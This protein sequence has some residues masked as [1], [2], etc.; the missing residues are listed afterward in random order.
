MRGIMENHQPAAGQPGLYLE[1]INREL[2]QILGQASVPLYLSAFYGV[3]DTETGEFRYA[4]AGHPSPLWVRREEALVRPVPPPQGQNSPPLGV[5]QGATYP[6]DSLA[7]AASDLFV[8]FTDGLVEATND[9]QVA[10][11]EDR[12]REAIGR[13]A[14]QTGG[15]LF[16]EVMAEVLRFTGPKGFADD[17]CMVGMDVKEVAPACPA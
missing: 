3:M 7:V 1:E 10:F 4:N 14:N 17:V 12:L 6:V 15:R 8:F 13:R 11:G 16:D 9:E 2:L 5:R